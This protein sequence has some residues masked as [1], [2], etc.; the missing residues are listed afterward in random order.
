MK[1]E[2]F[3]N[4]PIVKLS[5][6]FALLVVDYCQKLDEEKRY[7]I[8]KQLL[9]CGTSIGANV[10]KAQNAESKADFVHKMKIAGKETDET[11][12]WLRLCSYSQSYPDCSMLL[13]KHEEVS[14]VLTK[15]ISTAKKKMHLQYFLSVFL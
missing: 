10:M 13:E 14:K 9:R 15:I 8:S 1:N 2:V 11:Y 7:A 3:E 6:D 12:Y 5:F 4:N